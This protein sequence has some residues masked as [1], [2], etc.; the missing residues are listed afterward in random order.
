MACSAGRTPVMY[1]EIG[2]G[3]SRIKV[4][5]GLGKTVMHPVVCSDLVLG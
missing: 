4:K 1:G 2:V 3:V 5:A